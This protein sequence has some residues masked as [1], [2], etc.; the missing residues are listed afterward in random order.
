MTQYPEAVLAR[1]LEMCF[2]NISLITDYDAGLEGNPD[3]K[4]VTVE[5]VIAVMHSNNDRVKQ[6]IERL[7]PRIP[8]E[9]GCG[10]GESLKFAVVS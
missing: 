3:V 10:C 9:R 5:E 7:V 4:S 2:V 8:G 6:V 1:E